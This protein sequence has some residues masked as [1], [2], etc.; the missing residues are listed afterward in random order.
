MKYKNITSIL[1]IVGLI[2]LVLG[3]N[4]L[5]RIRSNG[6]GGGYDGDGGESSDSKNLTIENYIV[7]TAGYYLG[8]NSEIQALLKLV[9]LQDLQGLKFTE[10]KEM[11]DRALLNMIQARETADILTREAGAAPYDPIVLDRL[12]TFDYQNFMKEYR[13]NSVIFKEVEGYLKEGDITGMFKRDNTVLGELVEMLTLVKTELS[14]QTLP[15]LQL[16][17]RLNE[18]LAQSSLFGSYAARVFSEIH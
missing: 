7:T 12:K 10:M 5:A 2:F 15:Q 3:I 4:G 6:A 8:A 11:A 9:E 1:L 16:L 14:Q 18:T 17:W 13:L